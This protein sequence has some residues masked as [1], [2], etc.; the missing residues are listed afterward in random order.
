MAKWDALLNTNRVLNDA[1]RRQM[2]TP[3]RLADGT[4]YGF[5]W[6]AETRNGRQVMWHGRGLPGFAS[7]FGRFVEDRLSVIVLAN[8][9]DVDLIAVAHGL[10]DLHL[11][12]SR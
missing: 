6:H 4:T 5:G 10:A 9:D 2:W 7:Y 12:S 8:G 11:S 3:V 1:T